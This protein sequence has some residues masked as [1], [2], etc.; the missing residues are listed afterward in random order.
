MSRANATKPGSAGPDT[1]PSFW[2]TKPRA[3]LVMFTVI[4]MVGALGGSAFA[5]KSVAPG[6]WLTKVCNTFKQA[7]TTAGEAGNEGQV[8]YSS[9]ASTDGAAMRTIFQTRFQKQLDAVNSAISTLKAEGVPKIANGKKLASTASAL[10]SDSSQHLTDALQ[11]VAAIP[12]SGTAVQ[13]AVAQL[14]TTAYSGSGLPN[15][16]ILITEL[17]K[18]T[19]FADALASGRGP[20]YNAGASCS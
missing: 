18:D 6:P 7:S 13:T 2:P 16:L 11:A 10:L 20:V 3:V 4:V 5:A 14:Y 12:D 17:R 15:P 19:K 1:R 9:A 8:A